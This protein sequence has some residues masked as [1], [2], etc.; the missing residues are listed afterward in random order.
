MKITV[1]GFWGAYPEKDG[2]TSCYVVEAG[3]ETFLLDCGSGALAAIPHITSLQNINSVVVSH[4]HYDHT[5]DLGSLIYSRVVAMGLKETDRP[6]TFY[7]PKIEEAF[8]HTY[9]KKGITEVKSFEEHSEIHIGRATIT[10]F[11][12]KHPAPCFA[13]KLEEEGTAI[14]YTADAVFDE[15]LAAFAEGADLLI[16]E[17]SFYEGQDAAAFGHMNSTEAAEIAARAG[18]NE[19][20]L[21]HLPHFGEHRDL[22]REAGTRFNGEIKLAARNL[23][24]EK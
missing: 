2:A 10:F 5:A 19:L 18:V 17:C 11:Q 12:T 4:R 13:M 23:C 15:G 9:E 7:S 14:V 22:L 20:W 3:G 1:A 24:W 6:L 8:F 16:A 21:T